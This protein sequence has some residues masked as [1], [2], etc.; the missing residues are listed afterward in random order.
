VVRRLDW[1][2]DRRAR[3]LKLQVN[4]AFLHE[5]W[6]KDVLCCKKFG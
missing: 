5:W 2:K 1:E 4:G 3:D 6:W